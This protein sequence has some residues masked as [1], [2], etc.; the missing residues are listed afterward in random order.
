LTAPEA[1]MSRD[2][3]ELMANPQAAL[4]VN[5]D[6]IR[7]IGILLVV[8]G[9][10]LGI[11]RRVELYIYSFHMPLFFLLSGL[12]LTQIRLNQNLRDAILY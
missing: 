1:N 2:S 7:A 5:S 11:S 8:F 3:K 6:K 4:D 9:H 12:I 10:I